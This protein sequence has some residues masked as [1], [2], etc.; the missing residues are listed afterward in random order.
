MQAFFFED[1]L[2]PSLPL[3]LPLAIEHELLPTIEFA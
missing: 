3:S 2:E 1:Y